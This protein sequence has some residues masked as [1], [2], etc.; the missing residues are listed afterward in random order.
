MSEPRYRY[1]VSSFTDFME[2]NDIH[3]IGSDPFKAAKIWM[4]EWKKHPTMVCID[5]DSKD[6]AVNFVKTI[7]KKK[8]QFI[9]EYS[10]IK[11]GIRLEFLLNSCKDQAEKDCS[12]FAGPGDMIY[13][14]DLG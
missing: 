7:L 14:F 8:E 1:S 10:R 2:P 6:A 12:G 5:A 9:A 3:Y 13:P 4:K 11:P